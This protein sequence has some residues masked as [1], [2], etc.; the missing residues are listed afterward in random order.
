MALKSSPKYLSQYYTTAHIHQRPDDQK[1]LG[2]FLFTIKNQ[3]IIKGKNYGS[4]PFAFLWC[5]KS[6]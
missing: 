3:K 4:C 2:L 1:S 6:L 5:C